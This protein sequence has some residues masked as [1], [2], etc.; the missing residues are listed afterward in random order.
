MLH[1]VGKV[2]VPDTILQKPA[3]LTD[4]EFDI[5]KSH[6]EFGRES[7]ST[8]SLADVREWVGAHHERPDGRGYPLGLSGASNPPGGQDPRGGRRI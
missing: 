3:Q 2:A 6:P 5:I 1:D 4:E 7:S 8:P